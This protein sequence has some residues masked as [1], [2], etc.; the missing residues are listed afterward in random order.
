MRRGQP[1]YPLPERF[2]GRAQEERPRPS[3]WK[4][5]LVLLMLLAV[6]FAAM[7]ILFFNN[8]SRIGSRPVISA[9]AD[10]SSGLR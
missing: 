7:D 6:L 9:P 10:T 2:S 3:G 4:R 1:I 5:G 8:V